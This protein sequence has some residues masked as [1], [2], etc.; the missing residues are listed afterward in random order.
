[1]TLQF[2]VF[3]YSEGA[4]GTGLFEAM[5]AVLPTQAAAVEAEIATVLDWAGAHFPERGPVEEGGDWEADVQRSAE[6]DGAG[7]PLCVFG[8]SLPGSAAFC[9]AFQSHFGDAVA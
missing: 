8:L 2:L 9:A 4:D 6:T 1:M 5:A 7:G 3:D